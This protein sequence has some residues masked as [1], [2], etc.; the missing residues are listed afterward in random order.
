MGIYVCFSLV[1]DQLCQAR[2]LPSCTFVQI[3]RIS[4]FRQNVKQQLT[5]D[6]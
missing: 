6:P 4:A 1:N 5:E 3:V 2:H